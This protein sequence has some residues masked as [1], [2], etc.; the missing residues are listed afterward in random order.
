MLFLLGDTGY[1]CCR[2]KIAV[3][4]LVCS[5]F[6]FG[7]LTSGSFRVGQSPVVLF[8]NSETGVL[9]FFLCTVLLST[10]VMVCLVPVL[11]I[12]FSR[13]KMHLVASLPFPRK[14]KRSLLYFLV[15][16]LYFTGRSSD[17]Q[18]A[19]LKDYTG[20]VSG[21]VEITPLVRFRIVSNLKRLVISVFAFGPQ[22][23][24][25]VDFLNLVCFPHNC[26]GYI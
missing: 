14:K 22:R 24:S 12:V 1:K 8:P 16:S 7:D 4:F 11:A 9:N 10:V 23:I 20:E 25:E 19:P 18:P 13:R 2:C 6:S 26:W 15:S 17:T 5:L 21:F 3:R